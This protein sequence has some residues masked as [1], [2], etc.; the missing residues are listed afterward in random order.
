MLETDA[1]I[2]LLYSLCS[3]VYTQCRL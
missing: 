2:Q 1:C 3:F